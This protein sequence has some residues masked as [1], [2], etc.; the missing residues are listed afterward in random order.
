MKTY[1]VIFMAFAVMVFG[2]FVMTGCSNEEE[3]ATSTQNNRR[4]INELIEDLRQEWQSISS[5]SE[6]LELLAS[7][8]DFGSKL[9]PEARH[10]L[11]DRDMMLAWID[12]NISLTGFNNLSEAESQLNAVETRYLDIMVANEGFFQD[13]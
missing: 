9:P 6:Y 8:E 12:T 13:V 7:V 2:A 3:H 10:Y 4:E 1:K 5:S 11:D